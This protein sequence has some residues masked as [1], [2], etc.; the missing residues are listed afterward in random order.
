MKS[1]IED[2]L[3]RFLGIRLREVDLNLFQILY[4]FEELSEG[5]GN[6]GCPGNGNIDGGPLL[7]SQ[8]CLPVQQLQLVDNLLRS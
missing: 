5:V 7:V 2:I 3:H 8:P 1:V 6:I 4:F